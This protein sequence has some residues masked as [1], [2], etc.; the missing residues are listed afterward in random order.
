MFLLGDQAKLLAGLMVFAAGGILYITFQD[1]A[2]KAHYRGH[3]APPL[4]A[5]SGFAIGVI[6]QMLLN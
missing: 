4:G 3:W 5:V 2:P 1:V 6:G